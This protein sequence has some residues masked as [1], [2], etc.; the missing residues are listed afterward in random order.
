[1]SLVEILEELPKL[2][3]EERD[4]IMRR[5]RHLQEHEGV[6]TLKEESEST[7]WKDDETEGTCPP[8]LRSLLL[9][10]VQGPH[11]PMPADYFDKLRQRLRTSG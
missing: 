7:V 6:Q 8:E 2:T 10:A 5:I 9:E 1:M 4:V 11:H 3:A